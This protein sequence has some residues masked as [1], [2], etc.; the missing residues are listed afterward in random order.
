MW[1]Q[2]DIHSGFSLKEEYIVILI[3]DEK[4]SSSVTIMNEFQKWKELLAPKHESVE[5][6]S[7]D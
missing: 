2:S 5:S 7:C 6:L 3:K 1:P 4:R